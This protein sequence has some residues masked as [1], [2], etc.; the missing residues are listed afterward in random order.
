MPPPDADAPAPALVNPDGSP[1]TPPTTDELL[2]RGDCAVKREYLRPPPPPRAPEERPAAAAAPG[3][4]EKTSRRRAKDER[5]HARSSTGAFL[6]NAFCK[7]E[8]S[9][10]PAC[11]YS[12]D[13]DAYLA[14][15]PP[16]LPGPCPHHS[17][18]PEDGLAAP[19]RRC[20]H[21]VQCRFYD[22][23][24]DPAPGA[25]AP[26]PE[27]RAAR[28]AAKSAAMAGVETLFPAGPPEDATTTWGL[29][30]NALAPELKLDLRK[31]RVRFDRADETL[32]RMGAKVS[33]RY[34]GKPPPEGGGAGGG[35]APRGGGGGGGGGLAGR[36]GGGKSLGAPPEEE[37]G[38]EED[39]DAN[40]D[41]D[42]PRAAAAAAPAAAA[43]DRDPPTAKRQKREGPQEA[44][45]VDVRL[46]PEEKRRIDFRGKL[47]LAPLTTVGNLPY[48]RVC[49]RFGADVTC[50]EMAM[51][52]NLLQGNPQEWALLRRHPSEDLFGAQICGGYADS[53]ARC[54]QMLDDAFISGGGGGGGGGGGFR[55]GGGDD[56]PPLPG[57][58]PGGLDFV[59]INM[60]CPIDLV[61]NKGAGSA[62]LK[63]PDRMEQI[64]RCAAPLLGCPL[65]LKTRVGYFDDRRV[66]REII[67]RMASWGVAAC[68]LH[69]RSRQQRYSRS[70]DWG[71]VAECAS[72]ARSEEAGE[73][74]R[75]QVIGNGDVFNFRD[76]ERY[77][78]KTDVATCMIARGALIKPWIF[79]EIKERRDWDIS[80]G[81]RFEM[82][83]RFCAHGLEHWGADD[84]GVRSTRRFLLEWLSFT[85]RYVPVGVLD[86]VP[87]GIH[88]R[89]PTFVG[90]SDLETLLSSSDPA[91]WV[92]ISTMLLG[93]TPSDFSFAPKHK[94]AAYGERTEGGHAKQD[95]GEV[96]G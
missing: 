61:C 14:A 25:T 52:T 41:P 35:A 9:Y 83:K 20:P 40:P 42:P 67:P 93:P 86:R 26:T 87:V 82:L 59:D 22:S 78:E 71:Y 37:S 32:R 47:Y 84:R 74:A 10:G 68:T 31:G 4:D 57:A 12:H 5:K 46:R 13:L 66:A 29:E 11:K 33:W 39:A 27:A 18:T 28:E 15:K 94:S 62:L 55:F 2:A 34:G 16:D 23:H 60:G 53:V 44:E 50:G 51:C 63:K 85:H 91:D 56:A 30:R 21:G 95:W 58:A 90:R 65:T 49:K 6:C 7:G 81:E 3:P 69:G 54:A 77:V 79:T 96:R 24:P 76:Y 70:A 72:A 64:A 8:C 73:A 75:F 17:A 38:D 43:R 92:K 1:W 19:P 88:Q 45:G 48:R 80:A 36:G 89:P